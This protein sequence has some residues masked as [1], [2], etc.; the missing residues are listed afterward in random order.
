MK[1]IVTHVV[2]KH[3]VKKIKMWFCTRDDS[4]P[5]LV[6]MSCRV[7]AIDSSLY[8]TLPGS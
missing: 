3:K 5:D 1:Y 8:N 2:K 7:L 6:G 4:N